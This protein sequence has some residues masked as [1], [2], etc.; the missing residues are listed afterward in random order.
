[1]PRPNALDELA[2]L[3]RQLSVQKDLIDKLRLI[4]AIHITAYNMKLP[5]ETMAVEFFYV[6]GD[7]LEGQKASDLNL[8]LISK[9]DVLRELDDG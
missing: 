1:M 2:R 5:V 3:Q 9:D 6:L 4:R 8:K 7:V